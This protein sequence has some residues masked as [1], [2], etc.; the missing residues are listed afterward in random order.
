MTDSTKVSDGRAVDRKVDRGH[1]PSRTEVSDRRAEWVAC[2]DSLELAVV[3]ECPSYQYWLDETTL[4]YDAYR[5]V[6][7]RT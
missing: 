4:A 6:G 7:G 1:G 3:T 2:C 5:K